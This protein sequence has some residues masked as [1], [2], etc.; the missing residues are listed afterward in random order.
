VDYVNA[1]DTHGNVTVGVGQMFP[2]ELDAAGYPFY[3]V[4]KPADADPFTEP[5]PPKK[6][7]E[8]EIRW[9]Y[10]NV[11]RLPEGQDIDRLLLQRIKGM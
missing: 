11:K 8:E 5:P 4:S 6:A 1:Q 10:R 9:E 2:S 7:T 3:L